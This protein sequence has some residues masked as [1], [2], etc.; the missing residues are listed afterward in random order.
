M[1]ALERL[2]LKAVAGAFTGHRLLLAFIGFYWLLL[3]FIGR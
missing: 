1:R 2:Q 3:A